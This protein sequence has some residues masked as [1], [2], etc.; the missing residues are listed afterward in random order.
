MSDP[1]HRPH[2][3]SRREA[4]HT[5]AAGAGA[6]AFPGLLRGAAGDGAKAPVPEPMR[7]AFIGVAGRGRDNL[8][9]LTAH[10]AVA[11]A[12]VDE[13]HAAPSFAEHPTVPRYRDFRRMLERHRREIDGVVISTPD[14][15][16]YAMTMVAMELGLNVFVEKPLATSIWECRQLEAAARRHRVKTQL[17]IQGHSTAALRLLREW[18]EA[19]VVGTVREIYLWTDRMQPRRYTWSESLAAAEPVPATLDWD[20][21]LCARP[22]RPFSSLYVPNR[23]RNWWGF[24]T[25][26]VGDIGVHMFDVVE[27]ALGVGFPDAVEVEVPARSEFTAPPWSRLRWHFPARGARPPIV[28]HWCNGTRD[29]A[30]LRPEAVPYVPAE[31]IAQTPNAIVFVGENGAALVPDMRAS[32]SPRLFPLERERDVLASPPARTLP[33][34]KGGH[35]EDWF[36][37]IR[38]NRQPGA[39]FAYSAPLNEMV[40][41]GTL[42]QRTGQTIRWDRASMKTRDN[43]QADA[44]VKPP[45]RP[46]WEFSG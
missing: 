6:L 29:G 7:L 2:R 46:G 3:L 34:P 5:L 42:A 15:A 36:D 16:H 13:A 39:S 25:G 19:G 33:R 28:A 18:L 30:F 38:E 27:F 45:M 26:P 35:F 20:L 8:R 1:I 31:V 40:L 44:L 10:H 21:W 14:H 43:P 37:A 24:G 32:E 22:E 23:W 17:G 41:L 9:S 12:D 11:F 4:L